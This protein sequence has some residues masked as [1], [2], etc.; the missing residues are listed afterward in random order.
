M[1]PEPQRGSVSPTC[2][3]HERQQQIS[4]AGQSVNCCRD[5]L[6]PETTHL[7][8]VSHMG[9]SY[10]QPPLFLWPMLAHFV[11]L[12]ACTMKPAEMWTSAER[13]TIV[14][15]SVLYASFLGRRGAEKVGYKKLTGA[16]WG[17]KT[18]GSCF[19]AS[20]LGPR[21]QHKQWLLNTIS[22]QGY[23]SGKH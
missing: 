6:T 13:E 20:R 23:N 9:Q 10:Q 15:V 16:W 5:V 21:L 1:G 18:T 4:H 17:F 22:I 14:Y 12:S 19:H 11:W 8:L 7:Q 3:F 2:H